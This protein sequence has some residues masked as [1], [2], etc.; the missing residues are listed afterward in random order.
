MKRHQC[1]VLTRNKFSLQYISESI[2]S[3]STQ[4]CAQQ[5]TKSELCIF[6]EREVASVVSSFHRQQDADLI[7]TETKCSSE[8]Q[9]NN[10]MIC[11]NSMRTRGNVIQTEFF[12]CLFDQI[13]SFFIQVFFFLFV[14]FFN[15]DKEISVVSLYLILIKQQ[16]IYWDFGV[17]K[18]L[19]IHISSI[20]IPA[21]N[22]LLR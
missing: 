22:V 4:L 14:F 9:T 16:S 20:L 3:R 19:V 21:L 6:T 12:F 2:Q 17:H 8:R 1:L 5:K 11:V 15:I 10:I 7:N 18:R 13:V